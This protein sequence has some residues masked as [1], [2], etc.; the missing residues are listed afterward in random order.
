M[1]TAIE[2]AEAG[3]LPD[4]MIRIG[5]RRMLARRLEEEAAAA[6]ERARWRAGL[7][8]GPVTIH[9]DA[10]NAQ[11]YEL[12]TA[13]FERVLGPRL[14]YSACLWP[15]GVTTLAAAEEAMLALTTERAAIEDGQRILELGCGWGSLCLYLAERFPSARITALSNSR[16]QRA[17]IEGRARERGLT[18]LEIVTA[19]IAAFEAEALETSPIVGQPLRELKAPGL[20][21]GAVVRQGRVIAPR[22]DTVVRAG[23]RVIIAA[24]AETVKRVEQ[25]FAVRLD[26]F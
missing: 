21:L 4:S 5:I 22:G 19:D 7:A 17:F 11:H 8:R 16:T 6:A 2:L 18:N 12:P 14:K 25:L 3:I 9:A 20:V 13:F 24:R 15:E 10:A 26:Y 23:D 1:K